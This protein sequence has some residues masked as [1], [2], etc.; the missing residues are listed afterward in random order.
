[1]INIEEHFGLV[2]KIV[3]KY[4][5][6]T[7]LYEYDD[8]FQVGCI[9]LVKASKKFDESLGNKFSTF[10]ITCIYGELKHHFRDGKWRMGTNKLRTQGKAEM[11]ISLD[12]ERKGEDGSILEN[13][14]FVDN[15]ENKITDILFINEI[16]NKL[17]DKEKLVI[18]LTYQKNKSQFEIG[19]IL[20]VSQVQ[21]SRLKSKAINK[22]RQA[23]AN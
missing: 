2:H 3:N 16:L 21:V 11:P 18:N 12:Y 20:G 14:I 10:A 22:L 7:N 5:K 19:Q 23:A 17:N 15:F 9:G 6:R 8:L 4:F 1:M 13:D